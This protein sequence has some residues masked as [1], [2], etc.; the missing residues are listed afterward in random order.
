MLFFCTS[1]KSFR[2]LKSSYR[3]DLIF[4]PQG[5]SDLWY[6]CRVFAMLLCASVFSFVALWSPAGKGL[7]SWPSFE[8][9]NCEF[10]TF[11][12]V[13]WVR[14][15]TWLYWFLIF[16]LFLTLSKGPVSIR[17]VSRP[18]WISFKLCVIKLVCLSCNIMNCWI[19]RWSFLS[20][21]FIWSGWG[22]STPN[23]VTLQ[24]RL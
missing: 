15:G 3:N 16:A 10:V 1:H 6:F 23:R 18:L 8:M 9:S 17:P 24:K 5:T 13:S 22:N 4:S 11:R 12:L 14:C 20:C 2:N 19:N 7:T 21:I